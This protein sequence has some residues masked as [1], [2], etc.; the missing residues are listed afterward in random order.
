MGAAAIPL[1]IATTAA[2]AGAGIVTSTR[3]TQETKRG[4]IRQERRLTELQETEERERTQV[5]ART[6]KR[7]GTRRERGPRETILTGPR[8]ITGGAP[9]GKTLLGQ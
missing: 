6:R 1:L 4:A 8:G 3:Q 7:A 2:S 9:G 5:A